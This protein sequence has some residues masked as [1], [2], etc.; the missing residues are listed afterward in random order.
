MQNDLKK[1]IKLKIA[2]FFGANQFSSSCFFNVACSTT[3]TIKEQRKTPPPRLAFFSATKILLG[4]SSRAAG[5]TD[6]TSRKSAIKEK[7][8]WK[9]TLSSVLVFFCKR[10]LQNQRHFFFF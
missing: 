4:F 10:Y 9:V 6:T 7:M 1:Y 3:M 2:P 8:F 5:S